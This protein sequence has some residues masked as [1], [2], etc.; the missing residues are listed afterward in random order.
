MKKRKDEDNTN[1]TWLFSFSNPSYPTKTRTNANTHKV[2]K[3]STKTKENPNSK[4]STNTTW[5][6]S[7]SNPSWPIP[8]PPTPAALT[9]KKQMSS[10]ISSNFLVP[11]KNYN[12]IQNWRLG[13]SKKTK[14]LSWCNAM[15]CQKILTIPSITVSMG[16]NIFPKEE[17]RD[18]IFDNLCFVS[19][20]EQRGGN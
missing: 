11:E 1:T 4:K 13:F 8:S 19:A 15:Q 7:F 3:E 5:L 14:L 9:S 18:L 16:P 10:R 12:T 6:F 20:G 2:T 17:P